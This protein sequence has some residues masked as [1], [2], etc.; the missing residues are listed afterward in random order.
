M[1]SA[2]TRSHSDNGASNG[3]RGSDTRSGSDDGGTPRPPSA[4]QDRGGQ[5]TYVRRNPMQAAAA[6][7]ASSRAILG[8]QSPAGSARDSSPSMDAMPGTKGAFSGQA[9]IST[10][11][12]SAAAPSAP[13]SQE[14]RAGRSFKETQRSW[15]AHPDDEPSAAALPSRQ[16]TSAN[17]P[18]P[19]ALPQKASHSSPTGDHD[20]ANFSPRQAAS[21]P[22]HA[23]AA[24]ASSVGQL[25]A[26][27]TVRSDFQAQQRSW[28]AHPDDRPVATKA[29]SRSGSQ[30]AILYT[31]SPRAGPATAV[32]FPACSAKPAPTTRRPTNGAVP[33]VTH[34]SRMSDETLS[35]PDV[36]SR[37]SDA[38]ISRN[39]IQH[40]M[41]LGT[42]SAE[43]APP[44]ATL[45]DSVPRE[46]TFRERQALLFAHL[47]RD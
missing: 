25:S 24:S 5:E 16:L 31:G 10:A 45:D 46:L 40:R 17:N 14:P 26:Q 23:G 37:K 13:S 29:S 34:G 27:A 44:S 3:S 38:R 15:F 33:A 22:A 19:Q 4:R 30:D 42:D 41:P 2:C 11:S 6:A 43:R 32:T 9:P 28:F 8:T 12:R 36:I 1:A 39:T 18:Q 21:R 35:P 47:Q 20:R 7:A